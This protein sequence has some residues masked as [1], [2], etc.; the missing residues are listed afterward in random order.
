MN[1][2]DGKDG[3]ASWTIVR[4]VMTCVEYGED[5][6]GKAR[7]CG[8]FNTPDEAH[9]AMENEV[10]YWRDNAYLDVNC[11]WANDASVGNRNE[12]GFEWKIEPVEITVQASELACSA[13][14]R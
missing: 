1:E 9:I 7:V 6:D 13:C 4:Y 10:A 8:V 5:V 3:E 11:I 14:M 12:C 2:A